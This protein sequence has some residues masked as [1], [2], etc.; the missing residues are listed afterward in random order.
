MKKL[1]VIATLISASAFFAFGQKNESP[2]V[3]LTQQQINERTADVKRRTGKTINMERIGKPIADPHRRRRV[4]CRQMSPQ[5]W[6]LVFP[7][8]PSEYGGMVCTRK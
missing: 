5:E 4:V 7:D 3:T 8:I 2:V 6:G 1:I